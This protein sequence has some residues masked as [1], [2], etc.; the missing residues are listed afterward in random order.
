MN[1]FSTPEQIAQANLEAYN[2]RDID[3]FMAS[4][5]ESITMYQF[6]MDKP[7]ADGKAEVRAIYQKLFEASP[8]LHSTILN[9]IVFENK[10]IDHESIEGRMGSD[11]IVEM[12]LIYE[13]KNDKIIKTSAIKK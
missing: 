4:F 10:V 6:G 13:I 9:R 1:I 5:D 2:N 11:T 8:N 3:A 7:T 12:V